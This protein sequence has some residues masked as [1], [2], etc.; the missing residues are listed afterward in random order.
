MDELIT[1]LRA[2]VDE[3]ERAAHMAD[4]KQ[5]DPQWFSSHVVGSVP[6]AFVVRST[7]A[8]R[9]IARVQD[10][11]GDD[12]ADTAGILDGEAAAEHIVRHDPKRTLT[13]AATNRK[14]IEECEQ[15]WDDGTSGSVVA[16]RVACWLAV[17]YAER[18]GFR[19]EWRL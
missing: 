3:D 2:Q 12:D 9:P 13:A 11:A 6:R 8:K 17:S 16:Y 7:G 19:E 4:V 10:L 14:I 15:V 5:S 1:W 18:P